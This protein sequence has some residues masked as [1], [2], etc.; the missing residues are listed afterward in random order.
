M[1]SNKVFLIR[2]HPYSSVANSF[3]ERAL[4]A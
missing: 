3:A 2:V 4:N 1:W